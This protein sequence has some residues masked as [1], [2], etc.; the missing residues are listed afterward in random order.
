VARN[1]IDSSLPHLPQRSLASGLLDGY[2]RARGGTLPAMSPKQKA[3]PAWRRD[4]AGAYRSADDRFTI[5]GEGSGRWF[6]LDDEQ[7]DELGLPRTIGPLATLEAAKSAAEEQRGHGPQTSPLAE[8]IKAGGRKPKGRSS[9]RSSER[10]RGAS[11]QKGSATSRKAPETWLE[12]LE[13]SDRPAAKRARGVIDALED[14]GVV[15]AADV[16][17]KD[18]EGNRA[19]IAE[20]VLAVALRRAI[21]RAKDPARLL[22]AVL[23]VLSMHERLEGADDRLPGW[24]LVEHGGPAERRVRITSD[25]VLEEA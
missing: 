1:R 9:A 10:A 13:K 11:T 5:R 21:A 20:T 19:A 18:A 25:D 17:R 14:I 7:R 6:L 24:R 15:N 12:R 4:S 22:E 2:E 16:V 8:R 3:T 23:D